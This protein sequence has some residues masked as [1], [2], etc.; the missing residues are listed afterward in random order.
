MSYFNSEILIPLAGWFRPLV[1]K[2]PYDKQS[3]EN[4]SKATLK[5]VKIV[6]EYLENRNF[7]VGE[8]F[9]LADLFCAALL[10]RGFQSF[11]DKQWR[12]EHPNITR[13]YDYVINQPIYS[14]VVPKMEYLEKPALVNEAPKKPHNPGP[15]AVVDD[16]ST[17]AS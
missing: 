14:A 16:P 10:F 13:W 1:G 2:E 3:V 8:C 6:E 17:L 15:T 5:A 4:C 11:F 12:L 9:S 7:L